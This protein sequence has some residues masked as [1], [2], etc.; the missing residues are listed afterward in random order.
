MTNKTGQPVEAKLFING[1][2][3]DASD[4][5]TFQLKS[6]WTNEVVA[7][8]AE[9]SINDTNAAVR[10]AEA[11]QPGWAKLSPKQR[12]EHL[13]KLAGLLREH[14][15]E[16]ARLEALSM[17]RPIGGYSDHLIAANRFEYYAE[18]G[19]TILGKSSLNT[20][21]YLNVTLRQP[22]GVV[23]AI[24]PWNVPL[25]AFSGKVGPA[26]AAGNTV[27]LKSSEKAPL[28]S[29][30]VAEYINQAG[31]PPGVVNIL[32][33]HG[34]ISGATLASHM[35][36]RALSFTGSTRTGRLIQEAAA[37]SNLKSLIFEL[38]GKSPAVIFEDADLETAVTATAHSIQWNSGQ[39]CMANSRIYVQQSIARVFIASFKAS[40]GKIRLGDPM[41]PATNHG[42]LAD[43]TQAD[44]VARY[45]EMGK[46][47]GK[48]VLGGDFEPQTFT[49]RPTIFTDTDEGA[50]I[51]TEEV[52]GPVVHIN[53]FDTEEEALEKA[54]ASEYGLY[55]A[56]YTRDF[57]R[58]LRFAIGLESGTVGVNC[59]SPATGFD[60]PFGGYKAS[61]VGREGIRESL[62]AFLEKK[63]V[64]LK[65]D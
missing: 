45:L 40:F 33:G 12:G 55:A 43:A 9:A 63:T 23:A 34:N 41:D 25:V 29:I 49:V 19:Y 1:Q 7:N 47:S 17:G 52:F 22:F 37:K 2:L 54:N 13:K 44:T 32:S 64:L 56:V 46:K 6:P 27:V 48:L 16:L 15:D 11:A 39:V 38:G 50:K 62:D 53:T 59:T 42:P 20:P 21:G 51:L 61:G 28:T 4:K 10:A 57:G 36:V 35:D 24:I 31:F 26:L 58:A 60:M 30:R 14:G 5:K 65:I 3:V 18:A 8:V